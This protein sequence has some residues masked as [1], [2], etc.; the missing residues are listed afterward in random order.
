MKVQ[1]EASGLPRD[2]EQATAVVGHG[3]PGGRRPT[4]SG[5]GG[6][7]AP[8]S[9]RHCRISRRSVALVNLNVMRP[10]RSTRSSWADDT[11]HLAHRA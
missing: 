7:V 1:P 2:K 3:P 10:S 6:P 9:A 4:G 8:A 5:S 11:L